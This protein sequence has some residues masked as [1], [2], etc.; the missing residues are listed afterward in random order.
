MRLTPTDDAVDVE[1]LID[2]VTLDQAIAWEIAALK[3]GQ[4]M[5]EWLLERLLLEGYKSACSPA[6]D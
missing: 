6:A 1:Q 5:S 4:T 2:V 3:A